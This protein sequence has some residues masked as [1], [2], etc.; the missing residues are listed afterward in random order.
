[1]IVSKN[2]MMLMSSGEFRKPVKRPTFGVKLINLDKNDEV[3]KVI[4]Y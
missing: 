2:K 1:M 3:Q 4:K